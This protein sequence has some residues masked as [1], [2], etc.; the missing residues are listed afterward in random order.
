MC[1]ELSIVAQTWVGLA[2]KKPN[3]VFANRYMVGNK[4]CYVYAYGV[5]YTYSLEPAPLFCIS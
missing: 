3:L 1:F 4:L 2:W 5:K